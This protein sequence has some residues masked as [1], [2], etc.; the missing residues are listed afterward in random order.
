[1]NEDDAYA[2]MM[3]QELGFS[4]YGMTCFA[5]GKEIMNRY[6]DYKGSEE[7]KNETI[8]NFNKIYKDK[9][10]NDKKNQARTFTYDNTVYV[11]TINDV[12]YNTIQDYLSTFMNAINQDRINNTND[13]IDSICKQGKSTRVKEFKNKL[14]VNYEKLKRAGEEDVYYILAE[15]MDNADITN[16]VNLHDLKKK[17]Y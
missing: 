9:K 5:S 14:K 13:N 4:R 2:F 8:E 1:M 6:I 17:R 10:L 7:I 3:P 15:H 11:E 12:K 16:V